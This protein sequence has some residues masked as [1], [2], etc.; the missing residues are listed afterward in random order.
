MGTSFQVLSLVLL[1]SSP[2]LAEVSDKVISEAGMWLAGFT[3]S[4]LT[5]AAA[6]FRPRLLWLAIPAGLLL[7]GEGVATVVDEHVGPAVAEE[8][9][10]GYAISAFGAVGTMILGA[11]GGRELRRRRYARGG[12]AG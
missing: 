12:G 10:A 4:L 8:F 7:T 1:A 5:L 6:W 11:I 3:A 2:V 9:G